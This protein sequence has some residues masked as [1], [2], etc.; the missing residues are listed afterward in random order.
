MTNIRIY[1]KTKE[2]LHVTLG[3]KNKTNIAFTFYLA[4]DQINNT[5]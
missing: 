1:G 3:Y 5:T 2:L 4:Q